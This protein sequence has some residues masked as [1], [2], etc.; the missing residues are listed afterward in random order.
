MLTLSLSLRLTLSRYARWA[1]SKTT[2]RVVTSQ[3][4]REEKKV[5]VRVRARVRVRVRVEEGLG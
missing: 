1:G 3:W 4:F 5:R 2:W